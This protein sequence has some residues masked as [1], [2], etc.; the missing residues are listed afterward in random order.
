[1]YDLY[2]LNLPAVQFL[3]LHSL[4]NFNRKNLLTK[5]RGLYGRKVVAKIR[6]CPKQSKSNAERA[7]TLLLNIVIATGHLFY[8]KLELL[9][10]IRNKKSF[11]IEEMAH[12]VI[13]LAN[14]L[15]GN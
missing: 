1:M 13:T 10:T 9:K 11:V 12:F 5:M 6:E 7:F 14:K 3:V 2:R 15:N 8:E 4:S